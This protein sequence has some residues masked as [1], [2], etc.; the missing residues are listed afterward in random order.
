M[1]PTIALGQTISL[2]KNDFHNI[3]I[4]ENQYLCLVGW[5][6]LDYFG[7]GTSE[8]SLFSI[9]S[10]FYIENNENYDNEII[11]NNDK[12]NT[13]KLNIVIDKF[14]INKEENKLDLSGHI[15]GGWY[16]AKSKVMIYIGNPKKQ[17]DT[18]Y[19]SASGMPT[20]VDGKKINKP[21]PIGIYEKLIITVKESFQT[22]DGEKDEYEN[23]AF[24]ISFSFDENDLLVFGLSDCIPEIFELGKLLKK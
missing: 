4:Y 3:K 15:N 6:G 12:L 7:R 2:K 20:Y 5:N 23:R 22:K 1:F 18:L 8:V 17:T 14:K 13:D 10:L 19:L 9:D 21:Y 24:D 16:G 11:S